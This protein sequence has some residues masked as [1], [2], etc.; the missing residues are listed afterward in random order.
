VY[1]KE[2]AFLKRDPEYRAVITTLRSKKKSINLWTVAANT[3][4]YRRN[5]IGIDDFN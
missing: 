1:N 3:K 5:S 2:L 4:K